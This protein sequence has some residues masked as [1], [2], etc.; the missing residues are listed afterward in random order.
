MSGFMDIRCNNCAHLIGSH[1]DFPEDHQ[2]DSSARGGSTTSPSVVVEEEAVAS[3]VVFRKETVEALWSELQQVKAIVIH[4]PPKSGKSTLAAQLAWYVSENPAFG[5][6]V[7]VA[8]CPPASR[9]TA[10]AAWPTLLREI[11]VPE[12]FLSARTPRLLLID[13]AQ[14]LC[15]PE[16]S[17]FWNDFINAHAASS[18]L[19]GL[20]LAVFSS[21]GYAQGGHANGHAPTAPT[22]R[23]RVSIKNALPSNNANVS[24]YLTRK[25]FEEVID[26]WAEARKPKHVKIL[27]GGASFLWNF[28]GGHPGCL[29]AILDCLKEAWT[30]EK[31]QDWGCVDA[32]HL[33]EFVYDPAAH[34]G[35]FMDVPAVLELFPPAQQ[36]LLEDPAII[37]GLQQLIANHNIPLTAEN[38]VQLEACHEQGLL[39]AEVDPFTNTAVFVFPSLMIQRIC[40]IKIHA[41][42]VSAFMD[43]VE[44]K[45]SRQCKDGNNSL[46]TVIQKTISHMSRRALQRRQPKIG[47]AGEPRPASNYSILQDEFFRACVDVCGRSHQV[48]PQNIGYVVH[49]RLFDFWIEPQH[50]AIAIAKAK[51]EDGAIDDY[52]HILQEF[53]RRHKFGNRADMK[54]H[55]LLDFRTDVPDVPSSAEEWCPPPWICYVVFEQDYSEARVFDARVNCVAG[56]LRLLP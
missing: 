48:L 47:P 15:R 2:P 50:W 35:E 29:R 45:L 23:Q 21:H 32:E 41:T 34:G 4:G 17:S 51:G 11:G 28:T 14:N 18:V 5:T 30:L 42:R 52:R 26:R 22:P 33:M 25:E 39:H 37:D 24:L 55:V 20:L 49:A 44:P 54:Q 10:H 53:R 12:P 56:P 7:F 27:G 3:E 43:S 31:Y 46:D 36:S 13:V 16:F 6:Q 19:P 8:A 40:E 9:L 38:R 1:G